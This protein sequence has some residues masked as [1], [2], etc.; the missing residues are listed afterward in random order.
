MTT[1]GVIMWWFLIYPSII[2][3]AVLFYFFAVKS[4]K[5]YKCSQCGEKVQVEYMDASRCG[6]CGAPLKREET[7]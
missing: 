6:M 3:L 4:R 7:L 1:L 2:L 5:T